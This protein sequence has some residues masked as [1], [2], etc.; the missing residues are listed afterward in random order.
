MVKGANPPKGP[1]AH[2]Q[3]AHAQPMGKSH[4]P[5]SV[6]KANAKTS[7]ERPPGQATNPSSSPS[8]H[9]QEMGTKAGQNSQQNNQQGTPSAQQ[10][11]NS[12][13]TQ[14]Q[15]LKMLM[16]W[17]NLISGNTQAKHAQQNAG[18]APAGLAGQKNNP[19]AKATQQPTRYAGGVVQPGE[20]L[21][22]SARKMGD[23]ASN[24]ALDQETSP[25]AGF[26]GILPG[27]NEDEAVSGFG[28]FFRRHGILGILGFFKMAWFGGGTGGGQP[29]P[30]R[31]ALNLLFVILFF[32]IVVFLLT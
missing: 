13:T 1:K 6:A 31:V 24:R 21:L 9:G 19:Q 18:Q 11:L 20:S 28:E 17:G 7:S 25:Q 22:A 4:Q 16:P 30:F 32:I 3:N 14:K 10:T 27:S 8:P 15:G 26:G 23:L 29:R 5:V 2:I 12:P